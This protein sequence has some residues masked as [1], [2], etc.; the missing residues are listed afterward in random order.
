MKKDE[1]NRAHDDR[2]QGKAVATT[3]ESEVET[4]AEGDDNRNRTVD[5][6]TCLHLLQ[7]RRRKEQICQI[8]E[9]VEERVEREEDKYVSINGRRRK[10]SSEKTGICQILHSHETWHS[11]QFD[12]LEL[13]LKVCV[14]QSPDCGKNVSK[15]IPQEN[16]V[17]RH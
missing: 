2:N 3:S 4:I 14:S 13:D 1:T 12:F 6:H 11:S 7:E 17:P 15:W 16:Q 5:C 8:S 9:C 10:I